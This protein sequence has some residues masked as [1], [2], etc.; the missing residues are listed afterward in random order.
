MAALPYF[1]AHE[2]SAGIVKDMGYAFIGAG[3]SVIKDVI[4]GN[5]A[6]G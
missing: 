2:D 6:D 5:K 3:T 4:A 1:V